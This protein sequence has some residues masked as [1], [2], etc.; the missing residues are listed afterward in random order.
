MNDRFFSATL[1]GGETLATSIT[2]YPWTTNQV[3]VATFDSNG[4]ELGARFW[5]IVY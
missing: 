2:V 4:N 5:L 1:N 3:A